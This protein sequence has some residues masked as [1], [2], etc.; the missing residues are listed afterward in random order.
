MSRG[1]HRAA[2]APHGAGRELLEWIVCIAI[3][4]VA[5]LIINKTRHQDRLLFF[6]T[7]VIRQI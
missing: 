5:A 2:A 3:A 6:R 1:N 7:A 4:V